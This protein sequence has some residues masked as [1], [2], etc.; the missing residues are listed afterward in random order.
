MLRGDIPKNQYCA[1]AL[2]VLNVPLQMEDPNE[3]KLS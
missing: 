2:P 1:R 3:S